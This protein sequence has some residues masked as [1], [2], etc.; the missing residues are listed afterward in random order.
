MD[1]KA[2]QREAHAIA[3]GK[4]MNIAEAAYACKVRDCSEEQTWPADEMFWWPGDAR[5]ERGWYCWDCTKA[6]VLDMIEQVR[7]DK[8]LEG[9]AKLWPG[10]PIVQLWKAEQVAGPRGDGHPCRRVFHRR[11]ELGHGAAS[12]HGQPRVQH[13]GDAAIHRVGYEGPRIW[14]S[15]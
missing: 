5:H 3:K 13:Q 6:V 4:G 9:R 14:R 8:H 10:V 11:R 12:A 15:G 2:L 1:L 7:L